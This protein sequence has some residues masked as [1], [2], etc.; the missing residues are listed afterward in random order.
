MSKKPKGKKQKII[1]IPHADTP[2]TQKT[3]QFSTRV[4]IFFVISTLGLIALAFFDFSGMSSSLR[5]TFSSG[6][7]RHQMITA[8][9]SHEPEFDANQKKRLATLYQAGVINDAKATHSAKIDICSLYSK[10]EHEFK[11]VDW[12]QSCRIRYVDI[13]ETPLTRSQIL[14]KLAANDGVEKVF[15]QPSKYTASTDGKCD[16]LYY[17]ERYIPTLDFL[18]WSRGNNLQCQLYDPSTELSAANILY[19]YH[20]SEVD[21]EKSYLSIINDNEYFNT[22]LGCGKWDLFGCEKPTPDP[23]TDFS[24][25]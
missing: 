2:A 3:P 24:K 16:S 7:I 13:L 18:D 8:R 1:S 5:I 10:N 19:T 22:S 4:V 14:E 17:N 15:G 9:E 6:D 21:R 11:I 20:T 12:V 23:I 25:N